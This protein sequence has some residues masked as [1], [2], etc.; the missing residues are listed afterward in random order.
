MPYFRES[1]YTKNCW[2]A[3]HLTSGRDSIKCLLKRGDHWRAWCAML[4]T[5]TFKVSQT[6]RGKESESEGCAMWRWI[7]RAREGRTVQVLMERT[8]KKVASG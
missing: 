6:T 3:S 2:Q 8:K 4:L 1:H 7:E 5:D